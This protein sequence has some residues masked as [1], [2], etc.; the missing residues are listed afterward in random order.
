[1]DGWMDVFKMVLRVAC[2]NKTFYPQSIG[3]L[4]TFGKRNPL[5][6]IW[7]PIKNAEM[8]N[9][10]NQPQYWMPSTFSL[11]SIIY[12][13]FFFLC[14][15]LYSL[16]MCTNKPIKKF[17][18]PIVIR[19]KCM[20]WAAPKNWSEYTTCIWWAAHKSWLEYSTFD[21]VEEE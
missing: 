12:L 21:K 15:Y 11:H 7:F 6:E 4:S 14:F 16:I 13:F 19:Y 20:W 17:F 8:I 10:D 18:E 5:K 3:S 9:I 2:T 1:M